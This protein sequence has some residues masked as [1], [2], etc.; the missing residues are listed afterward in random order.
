MLPFDAMMGSLNFKG[1]VVKQ[2]CNSLVRDGV[3]GVQWGEGQGQYRRSLWVH[4]Q[5]NNQLLKLRVT[6]CLW[7]HQQVNNQLLKLRVTLCLQIAYIRKKYIYVKYKRQN[8]YFGFRRIYFARKTNKTI[9]V[10][11]ACLRMK[12]FH[13]FDLNNPAICCFLKPSFYRYE[14]KPE[15]WTKYAKWDKFKYTRNLIHEGTSINV[16]WFLKVKKFWPQTLQYSL[17]HLLAHKSPTTTTPKE[18]TNHRMSL[19]IS[20][21]TSAS[22]NEPLHLQMNLR[23]SKWNSA[24]PNELPHPYNEHPQMPKNHFISYRDSA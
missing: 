7:V 11:Y 22:P 4:Q 17:C 8:K 15:D 23:I 18:P 2:C 1:T 24:S 19:C 21:W 5:V 9:L 10:D 16:L 6:L 20:K 3:C 13:A 14:S 12:V